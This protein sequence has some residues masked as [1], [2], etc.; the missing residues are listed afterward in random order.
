[1]YCHMSGLITPRKPTDG[2]PWGERGP[3]FP[4]S[5]IRGLAASKLAA[6]KSERDAQD[7]MI[8]A[9]QNVHASFAVHHEGPGIVELARPAARPAPHAQR[10]SLR[11]EFLHALVAILD[12]V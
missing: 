2:I 8:L 5:A 1:M 4:R 3:Q 9:V 7:A 12:D 11:R 6:S 10:L